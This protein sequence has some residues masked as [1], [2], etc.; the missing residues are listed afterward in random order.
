MNM[1]QDS[2]QQATE[3]CCT[4]CSKNYIYRYG[5]RS[6]IRVGT[7]VC[8]D[9]VWCE[10]CYPNQY[11]DWNYCD[12]EPCL[13]CPAG[14]VG[15]GAPADQCQTCQPGFR[16]STATGTCIACEAGTYQD[17]VHQPTC[18]T[19]SADTC[20]AGQG[21]T[22]VCGGTA[23][24][25]CEN[26]L[27]GSYK[28]GTGTSCTSCPDGKYQ[29]R[30]GQTSCLT[31]RVC[32]PGEATTRTYTRESNTECTPCTGDWTTLLGSE[33]SCTYCR[34]GKYKMSGGQCA[35]CVCAAGTQTYI[36]CPAGSTAVSCPA[37]TGGDQSTTICATG[38]E[39]NLKCDGTQTT[40]T[41]CVPCPASK[42]K[43]S[44]V[45]KWC[46][47][48]PTGKY[49]APTADP[50]VA[51]L[52]CAACTNKLP[53]ASGVATYDPWPS[54]VRASNAC[55]WS[56]V[57]GYYKP[58]SGTAACVACN[59]TRG[60]Y[61]PAGTSGQC[62]ACTNKPA[63]SYYQQPRGFDGRTNTCPW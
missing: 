63:N 13:S 32:N 10:Y 33:S 21:R 7:G 62:L 36:Q 23:N 50:N 9:Q 5:T 2:S 19:C 57:A 30:T 14:T 24:I 25:Q 56:C 31:P 49:K 29:D 1:F 41:D 22:R 16:A 12:R 48:C 47:L 28:A 54:A 15:T 20:P 44:S 6:E 55:P 45:D 46:E 8:R 52:P 17:Q 27:A 43:P 26:C 51:K 58:T 18:K 53:L 34:A 35:T 60:R 38:F 61:A 42:Q 4:Q 3:D 37:C 59:A 39:P 40:N 11:K